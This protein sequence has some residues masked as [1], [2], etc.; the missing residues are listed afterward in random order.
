MIFELKQSDKNDEFYFTLKDADGKP[1]IFSEGYKQKASALNGIES[2]KNN[3]AADRFELKTSET[4]LLR[5]QDYMY[6]SKKKRWEGENKVI[7]GYVQ[8]AKQR[9]RVYRNTVL[10]NLNI[11]QSEV[12]VAN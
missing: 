3:T 8:S 9:V 10:V 11:T 6:L 4:F 2:V 7:Q 5:V 12:K 1:L